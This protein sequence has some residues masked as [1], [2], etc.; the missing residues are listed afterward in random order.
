MPNIQRGARAFLAT[1]VAAA[2]V[3]IAGPATS[4]Y[5]INEVQCKGGESFL[6]IYSHGGGDQV[7]CYAN[8]GKMDIGDRWVDKIETGN[9]DLVYYDA[10]G[11]S[12]KIARNHVMTFPHHPPK[13]SA[14]EIL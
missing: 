11:D 10:N 6:K 9:N 14:I 4:A 12:V 7:H 13:I 5:A 8:K 3:T 1:L 2:A